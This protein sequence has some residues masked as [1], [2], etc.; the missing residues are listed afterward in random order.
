MNLSRLSASDLE[1]QARNV[2]LQ[3]R[4][5]DHRPRPTPSERQLAVELKKQRL[6]LKDR[7]ENNVK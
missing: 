2:E 6:S 3:I 5:L 4:K 7:L 1:A